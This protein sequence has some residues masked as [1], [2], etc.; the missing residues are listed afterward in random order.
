MIKKRIIITYLIISLLTACFI[1][2]PAY[3]STL[4]DLTQQKKDLQ[5]SIA[6]NKQQ[7]SS[8]QDMISNIDS[9]TAATQKQ[10]AI[11][12]QIIGLTNQEIADTQGQIEVTQKELDGK[13]TDLNETV[14]TYYENGAE[15]STLEVVVAADNL[16]DA[17]DETQY[18]QS[19]ADQLDA[20]AQEIIKAKAELQ[21]KKDDLE[22]KE[23]DLENQKASLLDQQRNLSIQASEKNR[24][25]NQTKS[26]QSQLK[27]DLD[28]VSAEIYAE[29]KKQGGYSTGGTGGYPFSGGDTNGVDPWG[30]YIRQC[31][32][33]AAWYFNAVEGK[34]W[35]NTRPGSG[36]AWNW[37]ALATDQ[38]YS[39]S[40]TP[41]PG[42]IASW[43]AGGLMGGYG[44][45]AIVESVNANGT[46]NL[47]EY[48]WIP[49]SYSERSNVS[50][51]GVRFIY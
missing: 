24:L 45:V 50:P 22:K 6:A 49:Y 43:P 30:F 29:R 5:D 7:I 9:Q 42:A 12:N 31:T 44:H 2:K 23:A 20:Q 48:N 34:S 39:V 14:V 4:D 40:G 19:I 37:P 51:A 1:V 11:T 41:Q 8:I 3:A 38:G 28:N 27:S 32:S 33:Y 17:I 10:T 25:L 36:S 16:S 26:Q 35:Y 13:K 46:F 47:S 18:M 15:T 21:A